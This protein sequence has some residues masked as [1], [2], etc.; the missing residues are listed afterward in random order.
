MRAHA[1]V[2]SATSVVVANLRRLGM[3]QPRRYH[4]SVCPSS[5]TRIRPPRHDYHRWHSVRQQ[6][7]ASTIGHHSHHHEPEYLDSVTHTA[8]EMRASVR[9]YVAKYKASYACAFDDNGRTESNDNLHPSTSSDIAT[10]IEYPP[11]IKLVGVLAT[12]TTHKSCDENDTHGNERYSEQILTSCTADGI[13]YEPWRVPPT[14]DALERAIHHANERLD[15]HGVLVFYPIYDKLLD[16]GEAKPFNSRGP[17]KCETTGVYYKSMDCYFRDLVSPHKDVE[18]YCRKALRMKQPG[19]NEGGDHSLVS[20]AAEPNDAT[21][22]LAEYG[23]IYPCTALAVYR[24]LESLHATDRRFDKTTITIINRSEVL[25]IPLATMLSNQGA[26]V[27]SVDINSILQ[28]SPDGKIRREPSTTTVDTCVRQSSAVVSGV[29]ST[30]FLV[31]TEWISDNTTVVNVATESNFD[32][33]T[34]YNVPGVTYVPHV[35]RV[36][37]AALEYNLICLHRNYHAHNCS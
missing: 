23:P 3:L 19:S 34:I 16:D 36:T 13:I 25:G 6:H 8:D 37:V 2:S 32:E 1:S 24:I 27:Y 33:E 10:C 5:R 31:P 26:T 12:T 20:C 9:D 7:E 14:K 4:P 22:S 35:G 18:G 30:E 28:F 15:V 29:P 11:P 17:N 21:I